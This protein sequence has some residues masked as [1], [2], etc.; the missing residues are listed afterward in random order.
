[1]YILYTLFHHIWI[2]SQN[3]EHF[4]RMCIDT[5]Y[6]SSTGNLLLHISSWLLSSVLHCCWLQLPNIVS[7]LGHAMVQTSN[8]KIDASNE[9]VGS[10]PAPGRAPGKFGDP[11]PRE[12]G[13]AVVGYHGFGCRPPKQPQDLWG[14]GNL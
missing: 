4:G 14:T 8:R 5:I 3:G 13:A 1:M 6:I 7:I 10:T 2:I 9:I 11:K 12:I